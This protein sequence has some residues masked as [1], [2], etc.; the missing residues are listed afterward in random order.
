MADTKAEQNRRFFLDLPD[1]DA[2]PEPEETEPPP[3]TFSEAELEAARKKAY[4]NGYKKGEEDTR[5]QREDYIAAQLGITGEQFAT[6]FAAED[7]RAR[8]YEK[9][10]VRLTLETL[11]VLFPD[12]VARAGRHE[13]ERVIETVLQDIAP[14]AAIVVETCEA[15]T[16]EIEALLSRL[17]P[18]GAPQWEVKGA[19]DMEPGAVRLKWKD[20]G[21]VRD[22]AA[23]AQAIRRALLDLLNS[24]T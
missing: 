4:E 14:E 12:L 15:D 16:A 17:R 8:L 10:S 3:P 6:L 21:A 5:A 20:G 9:E 19:A 18:E 24:D 2:P 23:G 1:F 22:A 7:M 11:D 13:I